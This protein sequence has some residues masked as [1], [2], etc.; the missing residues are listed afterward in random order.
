MPSHYLRALL[1]IFAS[2]TTMNAALVQAGVNPTPL[3]TH[4]EAHTTS[5]YQYQHHRERSFPHKPTL[6][7][8]A[9]STIHITVLDQT[10]VIDQTRWAQEDLRWTSNQPALHT[11]LQQLTKDLAEIPALVTLTH[12][13]Q[14]QSIDNLQELTT[15]SYA[16]ANQF[17]GSFA[18]T[19]PPATTKLVREQIQSWFKNPTAIQDLYS[20]DIKLFLLPFGHTHLPNQ[21]YRYNTTLSHPLSQVPLPAQAQF[22]PPHYRDDHRQLTVE[23]D[24]TIDQHTG[25][26]LIE[27]MTKTMLKTMGIAVEKTPTLP[28]L[29]MREHAAFTISL[30]AGWPEMIDWTR[31]IQLG[32]ATEIDHVRMQRITER[33]PSATTMEHP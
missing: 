20:R 17:L 4:W 31:T 22:S 10:P 7:D 8:D 6:I 5:A 23:W 13:G 27:D 26:R 24:L 11:Q 16:L 28:P 30:P 33:A 9:S 14:I 2:S 21:P 19:A 32:N 3:E 29:T 12:T 18:Q 15:Q 25:R 1:F